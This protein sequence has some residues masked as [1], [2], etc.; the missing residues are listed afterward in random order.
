MPQIAFHNDTYTTL[1]KLRAHSILISKGRR[2]TWD[3]IFKTLVKISEENPGRFDYL[4][5]MK[6]DNPEL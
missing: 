4:F 5:R 6:Q 2:V 3:I 1:A